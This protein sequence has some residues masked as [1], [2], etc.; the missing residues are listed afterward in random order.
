[1]IHKFI[2]IITRSR[3]NVFHGGIGLSIKEN[4]H[5]VIREDLSVF[6]P[7]VFESLFIECKNPSLQ[8]EIVGVIFRP[9]TAPK[10]D[11][12]IFSKTIN[13]IMCI[14]NDEKK[15]CIMMGDMNIDLL[16]YNEHAKTNSYIDMVF[17]NGFIPSITKPTRISSH[18]ATLIDH[19]YSNTYNPKCTTG[20][21][22]TDLA[23]HYG[24]FYLY[25]KHR[26]KRENQ[27]HLKRIISD[28]N[29]LSFKQALARVDFSEILCQSDTERA[30]NKFGI[31]INE[32]YNK[33]FPLREIN[34]KTRIRDPWIS[35][36]IIQSSKTKLKLFKKKQKNPTQINIQAYSNFN[37]SFNKIKREAKIKYFEEK[38]TE[39]KNDIK[40]TWKLINK[41]LNKSSPTINHP[42]SIRHNHIDITD[43]QNIASLFNEYFTNVGNNTRNM[44]PRDK[45]YDY[46]ATMPAGN[47]RSFF[48][49]PVNSHD[50][51]DVIHKLK[52]KS[53]SGHDNISSNVLK[54]IVPYIIEVLTH[55]INLSLS[56]GTFPYDMKIAKVIPI[57]KSG[58]TAEVKNDRPI[59]LLT[60]FSKILERIVYNKLMS[61]LE[62]NN[63]LYE[64]QYG[65]RPKH[66]T[67]HPLIH[68]MDGCAKS[69]NHNPTQVTM[70]IMCDLS[71]AFDVINHDILLFKLERYGVRGVAK[72][73]FTSYLTNRKQFVKIKSSHSGLC[74]IP[75]GVPQGSILGPLL[76]LIYIND[77]QYASNEKIISF[78]DDTT[79]YMSSDNYTS[80]YE[81]ANATLA[82]LF[83]WFCANELF[84]NASKT[85]SI[86]FKPS[87]K[88]GQQ[89]N[90]NLHINNR[91][92]DHVGELFTEKSTKF[93]GIHLDE[94]LTWK[95]H[96][97]YITVKLPEY[98][99]LLDRYKIFYL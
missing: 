94:H 76:F 13:D 41:A 38:F 97:N 23:D 3:S 47:D 11:L 28:V 83:D 67:I 14:I 68:L 58:D 52:P 70:A 95:A 62:C 19:I 84:L 88:H 56:S 78:A 36:A 73:W 51:A 24:V 50:V 43:S 60:S 26:C 86:I 44:I 48:L 64:H 12:D 35:N 77:I 17:A 57:F 92:V 79:I 45:H 7:H 22:I 74:N 25:P 9:N 39:S 96:T 69:M 89:N 40:E 18:S 81:T 2:Y 27:V 34:T 59:S 98:Y 87:N 1:M 91:I 72:E 93:L 42:T 90:L 63:I 65:F 5:Y 75:C 33:A 99:L 53:S 8:N 6:I 20:I 82:S 71:K 15:H 46:K 21:L 32:E 30:F 10:A 55:I 85:K 31:L 61:F 80:L 29:M 66:S 54:Q 37:S 49:G 4:V 16:K